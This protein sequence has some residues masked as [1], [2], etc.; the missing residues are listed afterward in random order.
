MPLPRSA[1]T[2]TLCETQCAHRYTLAAINVLQR[3]CMF[4]QFYHSDGL[5]SAG[6][7][8]I[9]DPTSQFGD[10]TPKLGDP[11]VTSYIGTSNTFSLEFLQRI[12]VCLLT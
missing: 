2:S 12:Y 8:L 7:R 4:N 11:L 6:S 1:P 9:P 3:R 5:N 10:P